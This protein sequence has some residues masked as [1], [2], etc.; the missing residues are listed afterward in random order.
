MSLIRGEVA[1]GR[2]I[3]NRAGMQQ[4]R[5]AAESQ[6]AMVEIANKI[7][8][9]VEA[10]G[11]RFTKEYKVERAE[12]DGTAGARLLT[13]YPFAHWDEWGTIYRPARAPLRRALA[14]FGLLSRLKE[15]PKP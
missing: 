4:M 15:T 7:L 9:R 3:P 13:R 1:G 5:R 2:F 8:P 6:A 10:T 14:S 12:I 11:G